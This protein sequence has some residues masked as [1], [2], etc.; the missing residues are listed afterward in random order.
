MK[1]THQL[2]VLFN[3]RSRITFIHR[4]KPNLTNFQLL[5]RDVFIYETM[6]A[7]LQLNRLNYTSIP[8]S[9]RAIGTSGSMKYRIF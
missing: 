8:I 1:I 9:F 7:L 6:N 5:I 4:W 3:E 2:F